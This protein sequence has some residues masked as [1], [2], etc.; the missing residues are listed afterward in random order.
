MQLSDY[1]MITEHTM[2]HNA[3]KSRNAVQHNKNTCS[4]K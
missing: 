3:T 2:L 1:D 4:E